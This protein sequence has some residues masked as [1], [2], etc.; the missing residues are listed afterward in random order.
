MNKRAFA[1]AHSVRRKSNG[2]VLPQNEDETFLDADLQEPD[3]ELDSGVEGMGE[4]REESE[5]NFEEQASEAPLEKI[6]KRVRS[7]NMGR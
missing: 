2:G 4:A 3:M 7:R 5:E 1:L 6:L